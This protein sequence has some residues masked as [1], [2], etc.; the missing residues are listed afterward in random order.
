MLDDPH[1]DPDVA[2]RLSAA[3]ASRHHALPVASDERRVTVAMADP[4]DMEARVAVASDLGIEP[5]IVRGDRVSIDRLVSEFWG[6][7][8][9]RQA[10]VAVFALPGC[11]AHAL[12]SYADY[13]GDLLGASPR[14]LSVAMSVADLIELINQEAEFAIIGAPGDP[15]SRGLY[16]RSLDRLALSGLSA[17][18][19]FARQPTWPLRRVLL[20]VQGETW[21]GAATDWTLRL[22][23]PSGASVTAL[24]VLPPAP[25]MRRGPE[26]MEGGLAELLATETP[27]GRQMRQVARRLVD[28]DVEGTLRL[29]QGSPEWEIRREL[30]ESR[31]DMLVLGRGPQGRARRSSQDDLAMSLAGIIDRPMLVAG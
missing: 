28:R 1:L 7:E 27:L 25:A 18:L 19:L 26:R 24:A 6:G 12:G 5:C 10:Y 3:V 16:A 21:D 20:I 14:S 8:A 31:F 23:E 13:L 15:G 22:V 11:D 9:H 4:T 30:A 2:R 29:C 17:P